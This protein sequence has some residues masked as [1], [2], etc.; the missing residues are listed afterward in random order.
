VLTGDASLRRR[1][2]RR[3]TDPLKACAARRTAW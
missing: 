1:P 3:V 2:M